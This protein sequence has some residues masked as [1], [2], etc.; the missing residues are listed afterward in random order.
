MKVE[1]DCLNWFDAKYLKSIGAKIRLEDDQLMIKL[2]NCNRDSDGIEATSEQGKFINDV[3]SRRGAYKVR[4]TCQCGRK[5]R[6]AKYICAIDNDNDYINADISDEGMW[7]T[8]ESNSWSNYLT[9]DEIDDLIDDYA[10]DFGSWCIRTSA[11]V[12]YLDMFKKDFYQCQT[13]E[14]VY[15]MVEEYY[16]DEYLGQHDAREECERGVEM[17]IRH[18]VDFEQ[19]SDEEAERYKSY[20]ADGDAEEIIDE[21]DVYVEKSDV[22]NYLREN[23]IPMKKFWSSFDVND[24]L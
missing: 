9:D 23:G 11:F 20:G 14:D 13:S 4:L 8:I 16:S 15:D 22:E 2:S 12:E 6:Y 10:L 21:H 19:M 7:S 1:K 24:Y 3:I 18:I 17:Y 5:D